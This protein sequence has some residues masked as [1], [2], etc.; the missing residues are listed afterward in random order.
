MA[1]PSPAAI[2]GHTSAFVLACTNICTT[3]MYASFFIGSTAW[4]FRTHENPLAPEYVTINDL[5]L[6]TNVFEFQRSCRWHD[7]FAW[8]C[9]DWAWQQQLASKGTPF[10]PL[11][12]RT[13]WGVVEVVGIL[14]IGSW[15]FQ[16]PRVFQKLHVNASLG[17]K[18]ILWWSKEYLL[19]HLRLH[20]DS[21]FW[22][23]FICWT[24]ARKIANHHARRMRRWLCFTEVAQKQ[25][26]SEPKPHK[27]V[28][29]SM[30]QNRTATTWWWFLPTITIY[31]RQASASRE[32][33][34]CNHRSD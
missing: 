22:I 9:L 33:K 6:K 30:F 2:I 1:Q 7:S 10:L 23:N 18:D 11:P 15:V 16:S 27:H 29:G 28:Q 3:Y 14:C 24:C 21:C 4:K 17:H 5:I 31:A 32:D 25:S 19:P 13:I 8:D 26:C 20:L 12:S 34:C